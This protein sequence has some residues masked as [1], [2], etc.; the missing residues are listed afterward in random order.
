MKPDSTVEIIPE[1]GEP[2]VHFVPK[3]NVGDTNDHDEALEPLKNGY[4]KRPESEY[5]R[6]SSNGKKDNS[7]IYKSAIVLFGILNILLL[8]LN[9]L[10]VH[11]LAN[12]KAPP[13]PTSRLCVRCQDIKAHPDDVKTWKHIVQENDTCCLDDPK[14]LNY[15]VEYYTERWMKTRLTNSN[16]TFQYCKDPKRDEFKARPSIKVMGFSEPRIH[17]EHQRMQWDQHHQ[18]ALVPDPTK[19]QYLEDDAQIVIKQAG[20]YHVYSQV[21]FDHKQNSNSLQPVVFSH[22]I[23]MNKAGTSIGEGTIVMRSR[24]TECES[25]NPRVVGSSYLASSLQLEDGDRLYVKV[26]TKDDVMAEPHMN[27]FGAHML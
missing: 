22:M 21:H 13:Q 16:K 7:H 25:E 27:F 4:Q 5:S 11:Y 23:Y 1:K 15:L 12:E 8:V 2:F 14:H 24:E 20:V 26:Y 9:G 6:Q 17:S 19:I 3:V 18:L 10:A